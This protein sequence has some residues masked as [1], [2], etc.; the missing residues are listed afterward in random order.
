MQNLTKI[1]MRR[2]LESVYGMDIKDIHSLNVMGRR[3]NESTI[4]ARKGKDFKRFYVRLNAAVDVPNVPK[5]IDELN[6]QK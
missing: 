5:Q 2:F 1:E 4:M 3:R 6:A